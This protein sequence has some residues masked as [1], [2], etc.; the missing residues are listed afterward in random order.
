MA[1]KDENSPSNLWS[2][3]SNS[4]TAHKSQLS[5]G[6]DSHDGPSMKKYGSMKGSGNNPFN[7]IGNITTTNNT[8]STGAGAA[9]AFGL[10]SG[11]FSSFGSAK[12]PKTP[13][14]AFDFGK[15]APEKKDSAP[16]EKDD[17]EKEAASLRQQKSQTSLQSTAAGQT[18]LDYSV[19][20]PL[21]YSWVLH[22]RPP[23]S[24]N[25]DYEKSIHPMWVMRSAQNFWSV[26]DQMK[27]P[28]TLPTVS[29]YH[30]F[31]EGIRP[32]WEDEENKKGG[33]WIMRLKKGVA[34]RY[35]EDLLLALIGDQF[36]E[37]GEEICGVVVSVRS[38]E[39]VFSIWT[40]NDGGRNIRIRETLKEKLKLP[41]DTAIQWK[42]HDESINQRQAVDQAR[43]EKTQ[44]SHQDK[45]RST[46]GQQPDKDKRE[47]PSQA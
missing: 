39:D 12:T 41:A 31:K 33:K 2:R 21:T 46:F 1:Q 47:E 6:K 40:K 11:A 26:Y 17:K 45:R 38:G 37:A 9:S 44:Q 35:W 24:K 27:R 43:Q 7:T 18:K 4:K 5:N 8:P 16:A 22:Y 20:W 15:G 14:N 30:F 29:D 28:S 25:Q 23:T 32:V 36:L 34:D 19:P 10:G 42:S 3:R 13:G